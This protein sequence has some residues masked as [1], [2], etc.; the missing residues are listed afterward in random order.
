MQSVIAKVESKSSCS[1]INV[2]DR[3]KKHCG[4]NSD[5]VIEIGREERDP[6]NESI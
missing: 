4:V 1:S 5:L 3:R 6:K 2:K